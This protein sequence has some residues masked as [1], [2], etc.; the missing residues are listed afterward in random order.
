M[1]NIIWPIFI[2]ISFI[3]AIFSGNIDK[4]NESIFTST[5]ESVNLCI[6][7]LGTIC[8]WNGVMKIANKTTI[9]NKI[10]NFLKPLINFLFPE[11]P[12]NSKAHSEITMNMTANILGL[13]NAAT[14]LGLN[15]MK[16]MQKDN[17]NKDTLSNSMIMLIVLNTA[18][19]QIIPTTVI[20]IRNSM[21]S[22]N[23]TSIVFPVW[24]ATICSAT[25]GITITKIIIKKNRKRKYANN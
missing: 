20:A 18:S 7:L 11:I 15:A 5:S 25:A 3:Y 19:L 10:T 13:G 2:I 4:V 24:I 23:P 16:T 21:N 9:I 14:P 17:R 8:L 6:N 1:L 22:T 12:I